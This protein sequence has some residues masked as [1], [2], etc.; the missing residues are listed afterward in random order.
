MTTPQTDIFREIQQRL[1]ET[2]ADT[3]DL[4]PVRIASA[5]ALFR[6]G[7]ATEAELLSLL[8]QLGADP[9]QRDRLL[10]SAQLDRRMETAQMIR[11][12]LVVV[13][14][15]ESITQSQFRAGLVRIGFTA[16]AAAM[17][18]AVESLRMGVRPE[19]TSPLGRLTTPTR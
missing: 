13:L 7:L 1:R 11:A 6:E 18:A 14:R 5:L 15:N 16:E 4:A 2:R 12:A 19:D 17:I 9:L 10:L 3:P 8:L